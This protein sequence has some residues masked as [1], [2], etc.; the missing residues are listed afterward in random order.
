MLG[1][2]PV[3]SPFPRQLSSGAF[4]QSTAPVF[5]CTAVALQELRMPWCSAVLFH[6]HSLHWLPT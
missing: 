3:A 5:I 4:F 1:Y 6:L 2:V